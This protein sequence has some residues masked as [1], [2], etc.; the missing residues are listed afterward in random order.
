MAWAQGKWATE[1]A[2]SGRAHEILMG[3][4]RQVPGR[5]GLGE[6]VGAIPWR[7]RFPRY[8]R[9]DD[10][11]VMAR[12]GVGPQYPRSRGNEGQN[13]DSASFSLFSSQR[14]VSGSKVTGEWEGR[15][16]SAKAGG[17]KRKHIWRWEVEMAASLFS[18][19]RGSPTLMFE[20]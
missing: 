10:T 6:G 18:W 20:S 11:S 13:Q 4:R 2:S 3:I 9:V 12:S 15:K 14:G 7:G 8:S 19:A 1:G 17:E 5:D 16:G